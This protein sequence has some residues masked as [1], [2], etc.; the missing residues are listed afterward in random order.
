MKTSDITHISLYTA[1]LCVSAFIS[2]PIPFFAV[3]VTLQTFML[4]L[5]AV[6]LTPK[7]SFLA[8]LVYILIGLVGIPV[9]SG[10]SGGFHKLFTIS[11]GF[12]VSFPIT[13]LLVS[14]CKGKR[15]ASNILSC[16][17]VGIPVIYVVCTVYIFFVTGL[18]SL[19]ESFMLIVP[20][21][22]F[23]IIKAAAGGA[24]GFLIGRILSRSARNV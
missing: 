22:A 1:L 11:G 18:S 10:F 9:F 16:V 6:V 24:F 19:R 2:I 8:V 21:I 17:F 5:T 7:K 3:P 12:I 15:L 20:F 14:V 4:F 13:A 23:D